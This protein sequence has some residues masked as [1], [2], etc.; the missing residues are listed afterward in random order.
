MSR[1]EK[2]HPALKHGAYSTMTLLPGE[3]PV[4]FEKLHKD[5]IAELVPT[6]ALE[7]DIVA[8]VARLLW[9]KQNLRT[10]RI[11][12]VAQDRWCSINSEKRQEADLPDLAS[13]LSFFPVGDPATEREVSE[14]VEAQARKELGDMFEL[15]EIGKIATFDQLEKDLAV[16]E[17]LDAIIDKS[18]KRLLLLRG[19][20]SV[21]P[22]R[23]ASP[24]SAQKLLRSV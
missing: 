13:S 6:G 7:E 2:F 16:I 4:A 18:L 8:N 12:Q 22:T 20:K 21:G 17:R 9:R 15:V 1:T 19:V 5:L 3:D 10:F 14:D 24:P 23:A 11:A